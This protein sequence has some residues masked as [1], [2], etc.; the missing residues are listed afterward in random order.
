MRG[1]LVC[2]SIILFSNF[3]MMAHGQ[4]PK[5]QALYLLNFSKNLDWNLEETTIGVVGNCKTLSELQ[6]LVSKYPNI[7]IKKISLNESVADCQMIFLPSSQRKNFDTIQRKI[8][9]FPIVLVS[10][11]ED[12]ASR[13]AEIGFYLEGNRL[14]FTINRTALRET[15]VTVN[16]KLLSIARI[17]N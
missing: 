7:A 5:F 17:I 6:G 14:K 4:V 13:G 8:G 3:F 12:L 11:D 9:S 1:I 10:E 16:D 2:I 15:R